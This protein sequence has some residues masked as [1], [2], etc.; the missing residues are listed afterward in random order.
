LQAPD[1]WPSDEQRWNGRLPK[2]ASQE[3]S[4]LQT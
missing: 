2:L 1:K 3:S 4:Y